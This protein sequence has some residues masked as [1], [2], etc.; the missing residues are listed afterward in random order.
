MERTVQVEW[1]GRTIDA[2]DPAPIALVS[3]DLSPQTIRATERAAAVLDIGGSR[4]SVSA[5]ITGRL[6]LRAEGVSSS[7]IEGLRAPPGAVALAVEGAVGDATAEWVADNLAVV[8]DA[9]TVEPPLTTEHL[10]AWHRRLMTHAPDIH[11]SHVGAWRSVLGWIGGANPFVAAHVAAPPDLIA[12]AMD[13]LLALLR[14]DDLDPVTIAALAH[15]Q[16]ETIHPFADGNGRI[17]R[18]LI[19]W[20][21]TTRLGLTVPPP[22]STAFAR[23]I[24]GYLSGL[25]LYR[26]GFIDRW[27]RWFAEAITD[28]ADRAAVVLDQADALQDAWGRATSHLRADSTAKAILGLLVR[29][30]VLSAALAASELSVSTTAARTGLT[31]LAEAGVLTE[32]GAFSTGRG[33]P[34]T[35]W[36][37]AELLDLLG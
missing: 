9:L 29:H 7:A 11:P 34:T 22:T 8:T 27:V 23:D 2:A 32:L 35:W 31:Q 1:Q 5:E 14:R 6:L 36:G 18:V 33:R 10:F 4:R 15:A 21:L 24:G 19:G 13:D 20:V 17:G 28:S 30:P 25:T 3:F 26:Q 16:F 12:P 37:A